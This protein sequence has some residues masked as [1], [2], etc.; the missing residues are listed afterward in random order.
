MIGPAACSVAAAGL[1]AFRLW[2]ALVG[3]PI[4]WQD[5]RQYEAAGSHPITSGA[6]WAGRRPPLA[7]LLW[8]VTGSPEAFV[9]VQTVVSIAAWIVLA[10]VVG[11]LAPSRWGRMVATLL[12]LGFA[13]TRPVTQWDRSVL[14]ESLSLTALAL[15]LAAAIA[16]AGRP[17]RLR[18]VGLITAALL[19]AAARDTQVWVVALLALTLGAHAAWRGLRGDMAWARPAMVVAAALT[20]I[21]VLTGGSAAASHREVR[22]VKNA[23]AMRIFPYPD[24][25]AWFGDHGMPQARAVARLARTIEPANGEPPMV[26]VDLADARFRP[27]AQ[28]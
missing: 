25:T 4:E 1:A 10:L 19:F 22:N 2:Q 15:L 23:L 21:V 26:W 17:T 8:K 28:W 6:L 5:S 14:S 13:A 12:I 27:L 24:R 20:A 9:V 7:P 3:A 18:A 11:R 16:W